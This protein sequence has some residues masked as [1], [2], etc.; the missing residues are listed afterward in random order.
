MYLVVEG[1]C[2]AQDQSGATHVGVVTGRL[3]TPVIRIASVPVAVVFRSADED[4]GSNLH[5]VGV[6]GFI[7]QAKHGTLQVFSDG[8]QQ[9][10]TVVCISDFSGKLEDIDI[11][12]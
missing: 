3:G 2:T 10:E 8:L 4:E 12:V 1:N 11:T 5:A 7:A 6:T 9:G